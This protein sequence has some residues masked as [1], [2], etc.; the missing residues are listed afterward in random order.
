MSRLTDLI[1]REGRFVERPDAALRLLGK[2]GFDQLRG[3][4]HG[5]APR[6]DE[7]KMRPDPKSTSEVVLTAPTDHNA[8]APVDNPKAAAE[9]INEFIANSS[10]IR[11]SP[12]GNKKAKQSLH[13]K[14][15]GS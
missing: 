5:K 12:L 11:C 6:I 4:C 1:H 10:S 15:L 13:R 2:S 14:S 3:H 8:V 9:K 7:R